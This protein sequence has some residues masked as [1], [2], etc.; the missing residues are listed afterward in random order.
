MP[1]KTLFDT[2]EGEL[3]NARAA[4]NN[5]GAYMNFIKDAVNEIENSTGMELPLSLKNKDED[6]LKALRPG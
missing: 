5:A 6:V 2:L 1:S 3:R 4:L